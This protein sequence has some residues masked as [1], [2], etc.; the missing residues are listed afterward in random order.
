MNIDP[1]LI[2]YQPKFTWKEKKKGREKDLCIM[3]LNDD[4]KVKISAP[5]AAVSS[6]SQIR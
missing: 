1:P 6:S 4:I 2:K 3:M 5:V